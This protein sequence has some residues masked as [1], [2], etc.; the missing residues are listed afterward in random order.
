MNRT[1]I[2]LALLLIALP[3]YAITPKQVTSKAAPIHKSKAPVTATTVFGEGK[4]TITLRFTEAAEEAAIGVRGLDG[5]EVASVPPIE[6]TS[7][8]KGEVL[9]LE[10]PISPGPG[11]SHLAVDIEGKFRGQ[12]RLAVQTFAVGKP[13]PEQIKAS[14]GKSFTTAGGQRIKLMP[15]KKD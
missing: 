7:F 10:V 15:I 14:A 2:A 5:L 4:A 1:G 9:V 8:A 11:R 12:R 3:G 13:S 6:K